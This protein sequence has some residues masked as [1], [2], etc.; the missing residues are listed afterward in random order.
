MF[1]ACRPTG[2]LFYLV[3]AV[4]LVTASSTGFR[5][6]EELP[7]KAERKQ[8]PPRRSR[9]RQNLC[10]GRLRPSPQ[11]GPA[12]T[13]VIDTVYMADGSAAQG[14]LIMTWPAF[15]EGGRDG[16]GARSRWM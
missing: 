9:L 10:R 16:C 12:L 3:L 6:R 2:R 4:M 8:I 7:R 14:T 11:N 15:V 5:Q 1:Q 13:S